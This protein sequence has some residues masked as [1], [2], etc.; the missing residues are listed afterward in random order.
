M[1]NI[2][3][4]VFM[5]FL[6][7]VLQAQGFDRKELPTTLNNPWEIVYGPDGY[8]W[9]SENPG[10]VS[11]VHPTTGA[12]T[13]VY[14]A[15]DYFEGSPLENW[16]LCF[17]PPIIA[18][19]LGLT[20]HPNFQDS[21]TSF[22]YYVYAYN[23][24]TIASPDTK[25]K[26]ARLK[27]DATLNL[28]TNHINLLTHLPT[29]YDH[30]GGRLLAIN[31]NGTPYLFFTVGD[32]GISETN[33]PDCYQ[34]Q[35]LNPNN[36]VNDVAYWNGKVHRFNMDGTI[37]TD[38][39]VAGN[40][41][42]TRGHRN[43]QGLA[44]NPTQNILYE[45]E[46]GDRTDDEINVLE[47]G[48]SYG[49]KQI[50]GYHDDHNVPTEDSA[51]ANFTPNPAIA[52]DGLKEAMYSWCDKPMPSSGSGLSWCTV[53][54]SDG[55]YY[56]S[57][58][59]PAWTNSLLVVTLKDGDSTDRAVYQFKLEPNGYFNRF[60]N[61]PN[62]YFT[63]DQYLNG[64]LRDIAFSPDGKE[65]F[66]INNGGGVPDKITVYTYNGSSSNLPITEKAGIQLI[67]NPATDFF[68]IKSDMPIL[69][70]E[71]YDALGKLRLTTTEVENQI[72]VSSLKSGIYIV[73]IRLFS[74]A[75]VTQKLVK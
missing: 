60:T 24:G 54:P 50:R 23:S 31:Q 52:N 19:T 67:P 16:G 1:K 44:Y 51:V 53:A 13:V 9:I 41:C 17:N 72:E 25:F 11:R 47:S 42:Y 57:T 27:W 64:R 3:L 14:A 30:V 62:P 61:T 55:I 22:I 15:P 66:L 28:V 39:P 74:G 26:I 4:L 58:G 69:A 8:L 10:I 2:T 36:F 37:P 38:N 65:I 35:S 20:L 32:H 68:S 45:I 33:S 56:N 46:H 29:S 73:K 12:K 43:P 75:Y 7:T 18:G 70:V 48:K 49:W 71:V 59:I 34:S 21:A 5:L 63:A 6:S 40:S